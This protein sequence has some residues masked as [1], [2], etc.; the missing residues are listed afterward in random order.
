MLVRPFYKVLAFDEH[1][2][3]PSRAQ[4]TLISCLTIYVLQSH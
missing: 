1:R 3:E 2:E 4:D